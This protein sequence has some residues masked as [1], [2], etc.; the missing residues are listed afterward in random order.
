MDEDIPATIF[1]H[2][3][4]FCPLPPPHGLAATF[5]S[6]CEFEEWRKGGRLMDSKLR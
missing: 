5:P 4:R 2:P 3:L 1:V 6:L